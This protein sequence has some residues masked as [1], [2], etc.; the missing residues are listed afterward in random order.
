MTYRATANLLFFLP[1]TLI[2]PACQPTMDSEC[3][4]LRDCPDGQ[5]CRLGECADRSD[6]SSGD[7]SP[8]SV[9]DVGEAPSELA[10]NPDA[11]TFADASDEEFADDKP[12]HPCPEAPVAD[13]H[14]LVLNELLAKVPMGPDGDANGDGVRH[15]HDD[16]FVELVNKSDETIDMT[17]VEIRNDSHVR[18]TFPSFCLK[19]LHA[20][21]VFGGIEPGADL[22]D[23]EGYDS[24]VADTRFAYAD[25]GGRAV[26]TAANGDSIAD[27]TYGS[28]PAQSLN[29][30]RDIHG[31]TY[32][33]HGELT[34]PQTLFSPGTCANGAPFPTGCVD[35]ESPDSQSDAASDESDES[36]ESEPNEED[37]DAEDSDDSAENDESDEANTT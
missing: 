5:F 37:E 23:G 21:V 20:A 9:P 18:F 11:A 30:D 19:P 13:R 24:F 17:G 2:A 36:D 6:G 7:I 22:P 28:H 27:F 4:S 15:F 3:Q 12:S 34:D 1:I 25:G 33:S 32:V 16:E 35:D 26:I 31:D 10:A 8:L 29:L 14:N